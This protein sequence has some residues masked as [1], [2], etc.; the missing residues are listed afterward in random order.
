MTH[1]P[2]NE[3]E[4]ARTQAEEEHGSAGRVAPSDSSEPKASKEPAAHLGTRYR[5]G[6]GVTRRGIA[7]GVRRRNGDPLFRPLRIYTIDPSEV[8]LETATAVVNVPYEHLEPGPTGRLIRVDPHDADSNTTYPRVDLDDPSLLISQGLTPSPAEPRFHQQMVYAVCSMTYAAFRRALGREVSWGF[9]PR[10]DESHDEHERLVVRPYG[11]ALANAEY[12]KDDGT[13]TFGYIVDTEGKTGPKGGVIFTSLSH[14]IVTHEMTHALLDGLRAHFTVA[15][16][17]DSLAF[18]EAF[19]D[20]VAIFQHFSY[21]EVVRS[22]LRKAGGK[23]DRTPLLTL[24]A[25]QFGHATGKALR[26]AGT[27]SDSVYDP[28]L[29]IH[30]LG[31]VLVSAVFDAFIDI[32]DRKTE[33]A[34]LLA[35]DGTGVLPV[36]NIP[37]FLLD[38][39]ADAASKLAGQFLSVLIRAIDYCPPVDIRFGEYLRAII[40][41]DRELVPADPWQYRTSFIQA[42]AKRRIFPPD[43]TI[44]SED[45]LVWRALE[46]DLLP[47]EELTFA[48]LQFRGDPAHPASNKEL[49]RQACALGEVVSDPAVAG[50]FGLAPADEDHDLPCIESVRTARRVGPDGEVLF[51]LVAEVT[52][53]RIV[54]ATAEDPG[55][56]FVGGATVII[57]PTGCVRYAVRKSVR[58]ESR[59]KE[60]REY[61]RSEAG[62]A[63][64]EEREGVR[65][66]R[67]NFFRLLHRQSPAD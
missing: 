22:A 34:V 11:L 38:L 61:L 3:P 26:T 52:Q 43:V 14:D 27:E 21:G 25:R 2:P 23:V 40:T 9:L 41:A 60:Q 37:V 39:L 6:L 7:P 64:W 53:R 55:F 24:V 63:F 49:R 5:L 47:I 33:K 67:H 32:F 29:E 50:L 46:R 10:G 36:G 65:Q 4:A 20:L 57:D 17:R 16:S 8:F 1:Q 44:M 58:A 13:L 45:E 35:S 30:E 42:F 31:S 18:H 54:R 66:T 28:S 19:A 59:V 15:A 48:K 12:S 56:E 51:D 62:A